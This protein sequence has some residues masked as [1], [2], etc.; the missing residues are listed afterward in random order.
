MLD[1]EY[2]NE[3]VRTRALSIDNRTDGLPIDRSETTK[4]QIAKSD[5]DD[6][7]VVSLDS[8]WEPRGEAGQNGRA[9]GGWRRVI[10]KG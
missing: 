8:V 7:R 1:T 3:T 9:R 4:R 10:H 2:K 5:G 6:E